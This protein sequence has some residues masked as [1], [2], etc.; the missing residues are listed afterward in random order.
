MI[1]YIELVVIII[2]PVSKILTILQ[3]DT[4]NI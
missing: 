2:V 4:A 3:P 1:L